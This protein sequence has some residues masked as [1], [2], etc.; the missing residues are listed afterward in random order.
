MAGTSM[1]L[2]HRLFARR[3][4]AGGAPDPRTSRARLIL[5]ALSLGLAPVLLTIA[6]L[7]QLNTSDNAAREA[8]QIAANRGQFLAGNV[9]FALGTAALI[10]GAIALASL[11]RARGAAWM[12]T[13]ACMIALGGGSLAVALWSYTVV[14]YVGTESGVPRVGLVA[15]LD[16]G[17]NSVLVGLAWVVGTGAL[18]G[19]LAAAVGLIRA[20]TVPLWQ[21]I[22]LIIGP[23]LVFFDGQGAGAAALSLVLDV[24]LIALAYEAVRASRPVARS[25]AID[26]TDMPVQREMSEQAGSGRPVSTT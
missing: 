26:L 1:S 18:L 16:K 21:P 3:A 2:Q 22:L 20:R 6:S 17:N 25:E 13:G 24:A 14:G 5:C 19:M 23:V 10:P 12:T 7:L 9:L 4:A 11:V 8:V 15:L